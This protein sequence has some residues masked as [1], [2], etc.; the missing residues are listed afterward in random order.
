MYNYLNNFSFSENRLI[1]ALPRS[2][3]D[4]EYQK[5]VADGSGDTS[6]R[7]VIS[8]GTVSGNLIITGDLTVNGNF[9]FGD[10]STDILTING[11][12]HLGDDILQTFGNTSA[13]PNVGLSWETAD[14]DANALLLN[15]PAGTATDV[16][17]FIIGDI[18]AYSLDL[19]LFDGITDPGVAVLSDD[20]TA[21]ILLGHNGEDAVIHPT[22]GSVAIQNSKLGSIQMPDDGGLV[23]IV[24]MAVTSTPAAGTQEGYSFNVDGFPVLRLSA[25]AD[26][27]GSIA[28]QQIQ[29]FGGK[30]RNVTTV[31]AATYD[32]LPA[33]DIVH[34]AYTTTGAVTS[35]TLPTAQM[36]SGRTIVIKDADGN[37]SANNITI[38]TEGGETIDG[39]ATLV[40]AAD[41]EWAI[42]YSD[43]TNWFVI[44]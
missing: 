15:L 19:G 30:I 36:V 9:N 17:V 2:R 7:A 18:T 32:L 34:V 22:T 12:L 29:T 42:L 40:M 38:D 6:V 10:A 16:P 8:G 24:D 13:A 31:A 43:G 37:A 23:D 21:A 3:A 28:G 27:S 41:Y 33:D 39:G 25:E 5:F 35:L 44:S 4:R 20:A 11:Q 1:N 26:G 14:A